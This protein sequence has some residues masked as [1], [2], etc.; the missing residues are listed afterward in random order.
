VS[1]LASRIAEDGG[2]EPKGGRDPARYG[3]AYR[4]TWSKYVYKNQ[5]GGPVLGGSSFG[6]NDAELLIQRRDEEDAEL[7]VKG[8]AVAAETQGLQDDADEEGDRSP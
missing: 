6:A 8:G 7:F 2:E 5:H 3:N 4:Y 1:V